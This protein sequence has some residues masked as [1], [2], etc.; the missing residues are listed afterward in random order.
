[1]KESR[2][3]FRCGGLSLEGVVG[4][5][6]KSEPSPAVIICHP[7]PLYGGS[8]ENNVVDSLFGAFSEL[9]IIPFKFNFRGVG[10]S[11]GEYSNLGM[12][13]ARFQQQLIEALWFLESSS[14]PAVEDEL[15]AQLN[16]QVE[17]LRA[18]NHYEGHLLVSVHFRSF[19]RQ[20]EDLAVVTVRETWQDSLY[21]YEGTWP[22]Y[23]DDEL[24]AQR[25]HYT[26]DVTYTLER[27]QEQDGPVWRVTRAVYANEPPGWQPNE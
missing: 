21:E 22:T 26:L 24:I 2:V 6:E 10:N 25:D 19:D 1:M 11:E 5:A 8:M 23:W 16:A 17:A 12:A 14:D 13:V 27:A 20:S 4:L 3:R 7:H 15:Q 18:E 9:S